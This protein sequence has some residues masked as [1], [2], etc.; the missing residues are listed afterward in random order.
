MNIADLITEFGAYYQ[1]GGQ[2]VKDLNK[3][4]MYMAETE[5]A[6]FSV[7]PTN[8]TILR[9]ANASIGK[10]LQKFQK[11]FTAA[12]AVEF[13]PRQIELSHIKI[14]YEEYPS[15][16][17][18]SWIG[19]LATKGLDAKDAPLI[20]YVINNLIIGQAEEDFELDAIYNGQDSAVTP[21]TAKL[22]A[23]GF[24]GVKD[25]I[26]GHIDDGDTTPWVGGAVPT[27]AVEFVD[28]IERYAKN[29]PKHIRRIC[30]P[31]AMEQDKYDLFIAGNGLK[32][33]QG[34]NQQSELEKVRN[35]GMSIVG[36]ASMAGSDKIWTTIEGN[37]VMGFKKSSNE[38]VF[39]IQESK[40]QV[41][42]MTDFW[43]GPGF[44]MPEHIYTNDVELPS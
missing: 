37:A 22:I 4:I 5:K 7:I 24:R 3:K 8:D 21:G 14:D 36:L 10:V 11:A 6:M 33:N 23:S 28:Y 20:S 44:W 13:K 43:K 12:G 2:S 29:I 41:V 15:D 32:Y 9:K 30:K 38:K 25:I 16:L 39:Q 34:W 17:E 35:T 31:I 42:V 1:D 18:A 40:R 27:D 19:F 26:N